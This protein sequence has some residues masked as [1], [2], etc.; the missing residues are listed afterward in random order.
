MKLSLR[1]FLIGSVG[2][3]ALVL[4]PLAIS[5]HAFEQAIELNSDKVQI[6]HTDGDNTDLANFN[7]TFTNFGD[8]DCDSGNDAIATGIDVALS[9]IS[10]EE[11]CDDQA[12]YTAGLIDIFP[13]EYFITPFVAHTVRHESYGTFFGLNPAEEGPGTIRARIVALPTP[14]GA[15]GSWNLNVEASGLDL[16]SF[17]ANPMSLWLND[18]DDSGPY[19]FDINNAIIGSLPNPVPPKTAL[20][21]RGTRR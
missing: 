18:A 8:G 14:A 6:V 7:I 21:R 2:A 17:T 4:S 20:R 3:A 1:G 11:I 12:D 5:A 19:C 13:F 16:S 10:C 15:C 9:P